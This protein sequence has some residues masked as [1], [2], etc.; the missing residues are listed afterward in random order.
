MKKMRSWS[1][2]PFAQ[3]VDVGEVEER[4]EIIGEHGGEARI[5]YQ[6]KQHP[7]WLAKLYHRSVS[8]ERA[9]E[10]ADLIALPAKMND[11]DLALVDSAVAW[12]VAQIV[13]NGRTVGVIVAKA[14]DEFYSTINTTEGRTRRI[15]LEFDHLAQEDERYRLWGLD[16]PSTRDRLSMV[17]DIVAVGELFERYGIVFGDWSYSNEFWAERSHRVYVIDVDPCGFT[18]RP[19]VETYTLGDPLVPYGNSIVTTYTDRYKLAAM[20]VR[21]LTGTRGKEA[22]AVRRL[23][24]TVRHIGLQEVLTE[25]L[26]AGTLQERLPV[27]RLLTALDEAYRQLSAHEIR[28][29]AASESVEYDGA[30]D[31]FADYRSYVPEDFERVWYGSGDDV[32]SP[33]YPSREYNIYPTRADY[34]PPAYSATGSTARRGRYARSEFS[35]QPPAADVRPA[36]IVVVLVV[37]LT[38]IGLLIWGPL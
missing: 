19:W 38:I 24:A 11:A 9:R 8:Q 32:R 35:A 1:D 26:T 16:P 25:T 14:P 21:G 37:F 31:E 6:V 12:P 13:D 36:V 22:E 2:S 4:G 17:R 23:P 15:P 33:V 27:G 29:H 10:L 30:G 18:Q 34:K 3:V 5:I 20:T 28:A 7:R